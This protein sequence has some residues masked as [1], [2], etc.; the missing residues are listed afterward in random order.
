MQDLLAMGQERF[1]VEMMG[2]QHPAME[3]VVA[4]FMER[5]NAR[6]GSI[7]VVGSGPESMGSDLRAAISEVDTNESLNIYWDSRE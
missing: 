2:G 4:S 5:A 1:H 3:T 6:G 7:Q